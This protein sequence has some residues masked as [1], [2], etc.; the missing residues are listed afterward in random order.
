MIDLIP[1]SLSALTLSEELPPDRHPVRLYL[2]RLNTGSRR[3]MTQALHNLAGLLSDGEATAFTLNWAAL[4]YQHVAAL[5]TQLA[6]RYTLAT[7]N[8]MLS[9]LGGVLLEAH[10]LGQMA[11]DDYHYAIDI[12]PIQDQISPRARL[13]P[14]RAAHASGPNRVD[15]T[16]IRAARQ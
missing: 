1:R 9:A 7:A 4:R 8:K 11:A 16:V 6:E 14:V 10:L 15:R 2:A 13:W 12:T 5:R 3:T